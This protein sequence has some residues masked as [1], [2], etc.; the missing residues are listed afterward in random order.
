MS[1][2]MDW[3]YERGEGRYKHCWKCDSAGFIEQHGVM[4]GKCHS[5]ITDEVATE[6]LR[7]GVVYNAPG[8]TEPEHV[9]A[10]VQGG[11]L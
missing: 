3:L 1:P 10:C 6:L 2:Q 7:N 5:S 8:T 11:Y 9:Y 4:V